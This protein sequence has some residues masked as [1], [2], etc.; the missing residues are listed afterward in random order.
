MLHNIALAS[1]GIYGVVLKRGETFSFNDLVGPNT[2]EAGYEKAA[3]G[4]GVEITGGGM[5]V[6]ASALWLAVKEMDGI[7]VTKKA[8]YGKA[9]SQTYV[10]SADDAILTDYARGTDFRFRYKGRG[11]ITIYTYVSE[12]VLLCEIRHNNS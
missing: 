4:R 5:S 9:F 10:S 3:D 7:T 2:E 1:S 8:T 12:G 6:V 11:E